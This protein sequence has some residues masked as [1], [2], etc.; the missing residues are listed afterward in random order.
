M[1]NSDGD[2]LIVPQTGTLTIQTELGDLQYPPKFITL[3]PCGV[4]S[5]SSSRKRLAA[6]SSTCSRVTVRY[7]QLLRELGVMVY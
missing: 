2:Y 4:V 3:V 5:R 7:L 1:Q 6:T